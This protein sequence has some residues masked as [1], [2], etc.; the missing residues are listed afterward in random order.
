MKSMG[1]N[2]SNHPEAFPWYKS[3]DPD[4]LLEETLPT[5]LH[6][7]RTE[8]EQYCGL[9]ANMKPATYETV[10]T[11]ASEILEDMRI[12]EDMMRIVKES[13]EDRYSILFGETI[14]F[15]EIESTLSSIKTLIVR[16][17]TLVADV[18]SL[19]KDEGAFDPSG[20]IEGIQKEGQT[21]ALE[22]E[23]LRQVLTG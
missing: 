8:M 22:A 9:F 14:D 3:R 12:I 5:E 6:G 15:S 4:V 11:F 23:K 17:D 10:R 19:T 1:F 20:I 21:L 2:I 13:Q 7:L 16:A 18:L